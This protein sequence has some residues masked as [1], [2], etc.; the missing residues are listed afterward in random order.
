MDDEHD[1]YGEKRVIEVKLEYNRR[2]LE[3]AI[4]DGNEVRIHKLESN[5][6][7]YEKEL[8]KLKKGV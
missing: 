2:Q 8:N 1:Y 6:K 3:L 5:I 7:Q 4:E